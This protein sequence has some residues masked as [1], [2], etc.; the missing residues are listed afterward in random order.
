MDS[1]Q[2]DFDQSIL[3]ASKQANREKSS[4]FEYFFVIGVDSDSINE[5]QNVDM[6]LPKILYSYNE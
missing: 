6:L 5:D 4:F 3:G 1:S 2:L